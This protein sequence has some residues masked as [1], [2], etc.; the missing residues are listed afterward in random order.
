LHVAWSVVWPYSHGNATDVTLCYTKE[1][2]Q[3]W[4]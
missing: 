4:H 1:I 2:W 3:V